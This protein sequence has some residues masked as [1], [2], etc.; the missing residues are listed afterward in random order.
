MKSEASFQLRSLKKL[1]RKANLKKIFPMDVP[2]FIKEHFWMSAFDEATFKKKFGR[3]KLSSKS[4]L[5]K[6]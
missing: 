2:Y 6:N 3:S 5:K 4:S 1:F